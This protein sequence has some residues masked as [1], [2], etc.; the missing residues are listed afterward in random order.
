MRRFTVI[1]AAAL[2]LA[3]PVHGWAKGGA[4]FGRSSN[5]NFVKVVPSLAEPESSP[6]SILDGCSPRRH[7]DLHMHR[8]RG[9]ADMGR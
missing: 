5:P 2:A 3:S 4:G 6:R 1:V 9:P 7:C 8:V